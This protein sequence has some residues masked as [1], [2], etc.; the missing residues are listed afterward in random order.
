MQHPVA[1]TKR[2]LAF[3]AKWWCYKTPWVISNQRPQDLSSLPTDT[4]S[5]L[6]VLGHDC[7]T[8]RMDGTQVRI[9]E[10]PYQISLRSLLQC[11]HRGALKPQIGLEVLRNLPHQP[12]E[13]QL[14]DEKLR[15]LLVLADLPEGHGPRPV[16]VGLLHTAGSGGGL[17]SCLGGQLL[18]GRLASGGFASGLLGT[19][20]G[21]SKSARK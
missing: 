17:A 5:Q 10:Q 19:R 8:L 11:Q 20:H 15:G 14:A 7:H 3:Q 4:T 13:R 1:M 12:L 6:N 21:R 9:L 18:A 16:S 2:V